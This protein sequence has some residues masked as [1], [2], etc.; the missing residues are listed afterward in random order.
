MLNLV[1]VAFMHGMGLPLLFPLAALGVAILYLVDRLKMA[2]F[3]RQPPLYD[4]SLNE[5]TVSLL[6]YAPVLMLGFGYW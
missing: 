2:Y 4:G 3:Y 6:K 5:T 1:F